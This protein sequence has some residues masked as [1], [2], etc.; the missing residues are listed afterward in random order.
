MEDVASACNGASDGFAIANIAFHKPHAMMR[1][2]I[3]R[4]ARA[5]K[6]AHQEPGFNQPMQDRRSDE[7]ARPGHK[8]CCRFS[9]LADA[10]KTGRGMS[11][12]LAPP[13]DAA[14]PRKVSAY[15]ANPS[16]GRKSPCRRHRKRLSHDPRRMGVR[17]HSQS[18]LLWKDMFPSRRECFPSVS[19]INFP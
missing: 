4:A 15:A 16:R 6:R 3:A 10:P 8:N 9:H 14:A 12:N 13:A 5:H 7:P 11:R 17:C 19:A 18:N 2:V 1:Q